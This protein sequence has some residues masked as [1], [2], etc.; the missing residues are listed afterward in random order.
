MPNFD[1]FLSEILNSKKYKFVQAGVDRAVFADQE[2]K[3]VYKIDK[4]LLGEELAETMS[5]I[6]PVNDTE[7]YLARSAFYDYDAMGAQNE[8]EIKI[9]EIIN[10][11]MA[12]DHEARALLPHCEKYIGAFVLKAEHCG[13]TIKKQ[14]FEKF[15]AEAAFDIGLARFGDE[16]KSVSDSYNIPIEEL[17]KE[18]DINSSVAISALVLGATLEAVEAFSAAVG[19]IK[20]VVQVDDLHW[21]NVC[22]KDGQFKIIDLGMD[23]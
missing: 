16:I 1:E 14:M 7:E 13:K 6:Y 15:G 3:Y 9:I 20:K 22:F 19:R 21:D 10:S 12:S 5:S 8:R 2:E 18:R 17:K 11:K 4:T 23:Y